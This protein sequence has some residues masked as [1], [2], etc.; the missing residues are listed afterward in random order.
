MDTPPNC[1]CGKPFEPPDYWCRT[2]KFVW[3]VGQ[4]IKRSEFPELFE[5]LKPPPEADRS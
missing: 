3:P 1:A 4:T 5:A 2:C